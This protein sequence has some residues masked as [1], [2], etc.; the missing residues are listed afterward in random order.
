MAQPISLAARQFVESEFF[1]KGVLS[2]DFVDIE[3]ELI[4]FLTEY[5]KA[6]CIMAVRVYSQNRLSTD[7]IV[8][9][10]LRTM[11]LA[12]LEYYPPA[13]KKLKDGRI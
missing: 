1:I 7:Q 13:Y 6:V 4:K 11:D 8:K 2:Y 3:Q 12:K 9:P 5:H 10:A